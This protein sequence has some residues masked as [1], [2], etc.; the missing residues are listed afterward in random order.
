MQKQKN[1][2][3]KRR[4]TVAGI[5]AVAV[6][7]IVPFASS[8][9]AVKVETGW[10]PS[11]TE[12][13]MEKPAD[14][15]TFNSIINNNAIGYE[16]DFV[17]VGEVG[18]GKAV[19]QSVYVTPGKDYQVWIYYHNDGKSSLNES[20]A[21]IA[22]NVRL[23]TGLSTW[24]INSS[25]SAKVSAQ[26]SADNANPTAVWDD[27]EFKTTSKE[28]VILEYVPGSARIYNKGTNNESV[29][30]Q[31]I[32]SDNFSTNKGAPISHNA[33]ADFAGLVPACSEYSGHI[34][35]TIRAK[36]VGAKV[37]K[38]V[39]K[40]GKTFFGSVDAKPGDTVTYKVE[41]ENT[42]TT[43]LKNVTFHDKLPSGV[44]LIKGTT[45]LVNNANPNGLTMKDI[46]GAN[47][48]NTG[49][50]GKGAKA[51]LTYKVKINS[52]ILD[53]YKCDTKYS[54]KN[55][56][57]VAHDDGEINDSST[58]NVKRD[59]TCEDT[60]DAPECKNPDCKEGDP[61][62]G[63]PE[64]KEGDPDCDTT[65]E[66]LE[67]DPKCADEEICTE[68]DPDCDDGEEEE[69]IPGDPKCPDDTPELPK[70]GPG[71]IALAVIAAACIGTGGI[72][73]YRSQKDLALVQQSVK[74]SSKKQ[75]K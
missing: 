10:G 25:K 6:S 8:S 14:Y 66:C 7:A 67:G 69:C 9:A 50:Y 35:Y 20:G 51:T 74:N 68:G 43:D 73:W 5:V 63:E 49:L 13:T 42:G 53:K 46:I 29:L 61:D 17:R 11:R 15:V 55:T 57:Y 75:K 36:Q 24:K 71:E 38:T 19:A 12:F 18:S 16:Q 30:P 41:F 31:T 22:R 70:T 48:F 32:F 3:F 62:C 58:I 47:G 45:V 40:D 26:I 27:A 44:S 21:G 60:P 2:K 39:S 37:S 72:Y 56:I 54:F 52:T 28:D 33:G 59:C 65:E 64:C 1:A 23:A 34:V 4:L